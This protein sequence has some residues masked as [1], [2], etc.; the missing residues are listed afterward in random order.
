MKK[1]NKNPGIKTN[2]KTATRNMEM[3]STKRS[4]ITRTAAKLRVRDAAIGPK[5]EPPKALSDIGTHDAEP[6]TEGGR[7]KLQPEKG[8]PD[9]NDSLPAL[10]HNG[11]GKPVS[12]R[13]KVN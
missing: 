1:R 4:M 12:R 2:R 3:V 6:E 5:F 9:H 10:T 13:V 11:S 8:R 7:R